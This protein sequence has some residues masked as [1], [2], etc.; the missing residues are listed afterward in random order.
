MDKLWNMSLRVSYICVA[1]SLL[2]WGLVP[3]WKTIAA[4]LILGI[5]ASIMN[6]LLLRRRVAFIA[7]TSAGQAMK[8]RGMG[9][10]SRL[11][12]VLLA[13]M[14]ANKYP[15]RFNLVATLSACFIMPF[16]ILVTAYFQHKRD[17]GGKG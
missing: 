14:I 13:V 2:L 10:A 15:D 17:N 16:I 3:T 6:A 9:L 8:R 11:A 12:T 4:G 7:M 5:L 1:L